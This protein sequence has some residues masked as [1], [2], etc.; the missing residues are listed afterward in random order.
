[1]ASRESL[2]SRMLAQN[3]REEGF[4]I[5]RDRTRHLIMVLNLKVKQ[6]RKRFTCYMPFKRKPRASLNNT[7]NMAK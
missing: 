2:G 6:K 5:G 1:V 7:P 4:V 3:L